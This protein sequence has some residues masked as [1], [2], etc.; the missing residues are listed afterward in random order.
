MD[1]LRTAYAC[2]YLLEL[3]FVCLLYT[4]IFFD[5]HRFCIGQNFALNEERVVIATLQSAPWHPHLLGRATLTSL[6]FQYL[7]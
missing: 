4:I 3:N 7:H 5:R 1:G 2:I 6:K